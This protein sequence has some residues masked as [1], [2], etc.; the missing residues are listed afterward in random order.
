VT[1]IPTAALIACAVIVLALGAL[2]WKYVGVHIFY[3]LG[4]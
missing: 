2:T 3:R 4:F 1:G